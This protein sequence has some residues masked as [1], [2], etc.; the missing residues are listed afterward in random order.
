MG[1]T[2]RNE[3]KK[4][5]ATYFNNIAIGFFITGLVIPAVLLMQEAA[6][7]QIWSIKTAGYLAAMIGSM[8]MSFYMHYSARKFLVGLE[9]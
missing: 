5:E 4:L 6:I 3:T 1:K 8:I 9:D 7:G 2:A